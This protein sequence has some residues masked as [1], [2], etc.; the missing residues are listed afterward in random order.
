MLVRSEGHFSGTLSKLECFESL[1]AACLL[2]LPWLGKY[3]TTAPSKVMRHTSTE[4][5]ADAVLASMPRSP[6]SVCESVCIML[7]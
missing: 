1:S 2:H 3:P 4:G 7:D 5:P 6:A